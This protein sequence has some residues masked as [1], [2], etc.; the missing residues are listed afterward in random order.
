MYLTEILKLNCHPE[1][2]IAVSRR[3]GW[4]TSGHCKGSSKKSYFCYAKGALSNNT[5][6][7]D[8]KDPLACQR[9]NS[10]RSFPPRICS[11]FQFLGYELFLGSRNYRSILI[12]SFSGGYL[13]PI[14]ILWNGG[15]VGISDPRSRSRPWQLM[16]VLV[17]S[18]LPL[19]CNGNSIT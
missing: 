13:V 17:L 14:Q 3:C 8:G 10:S 16:I 18:Q 1:F 12:P 15:Y 4:L 11:S 19:L 6:C 7:R 5:V 2:I 9:S